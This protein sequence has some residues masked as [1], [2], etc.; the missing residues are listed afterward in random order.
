MEGTRTMKEEL[1][2][3]E[4]AVADVDYL[5]ND[6]LRISRAELDKLKTLADTLHGIAETYEMPI[7]KLLKED[8]S[9]VREG[10]SLSGA[11]GVSEARGNRAAK[12]VAVKPAPWVASHTIGPEKQDTT[13]SV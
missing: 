5:M 7:F 8:S 12:Q 6:G 2:A 9:S 4:T 10:T 1:K 13:S 11:G 3:L